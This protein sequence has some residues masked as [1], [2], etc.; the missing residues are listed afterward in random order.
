MVHNSARPSQ[1][2]VRGDDSCMRRR[3]VGAAANED[4]PGGTFLPS[5][6]PIRL[7]NSRLHGL[8]ATSSF[9]KYFEPEEG[10]ETRDT[11]RRA[12]GGGRTL[13]ADRCNGPLQAAAAAPR[14]NFITRPQ[15]G[16]AAESTR[17]YYV[18]GR[19]RQ[20]H[21]TPLRATRVA[22]QVSK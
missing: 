17:S 13:R 19:R 2:R 21:L 14:T 3:R 15:R 8:P 10:Q 18:A 5:F 20:A 11:R 7:R 1:T 9:S 16:A 4:F 12:D 6:L 22:I